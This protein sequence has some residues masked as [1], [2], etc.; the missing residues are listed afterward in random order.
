MADRTREGKQPPRIAVLLHSLEMG[1]A[2]RVLV[3]LC[4]QFAA[5]GHR[6]DMV[7]VRNQGELTANLSAQVRLVDLSAPNAYLAIPA[8]VRYLHQEEP[9]V[10]LSSF[11]LLSL[12]VLLLRRILG[13]SSQVVVRIATTLSLNRRMAYKK[14]LE[15][16]L[17]SWLYP[18]AEAIVLV[19]KSAAQ[20]LASFAGFSSER[21]HVVYNPVITD[22]FLQDM[23]ED[24]H[25]PFFEAGEPPVILGVGRLNKAKDFPSLIRAFADLRKRIPARLLILG[26]GELRVE[27]Q[28]LVN[29]LDLR[30]DVDLPGFVMNPVAYMRRSDVFVLSSRWEGLPGV[31]IQALAAG[32][33]VV[34]TDCPSGPREILADGEYGHLVPV[35]DTEALVAAIEDVLKGHGRK[36][37]PAW[38]EQFKVEP[39]VRKYMQ[40]IGIEE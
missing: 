9:Q 3:E 13:F 11:E 25:H 22:Q 36:V 35:G 10:I 32:C 8:L 20:D 12:I 19:S 31:L 27:L 7:L 40:I 24:A 37:D 33:P 2:E 28:G 17:V 15:R 29:S 18:Q 14:W 21:V 1:G 5:R 34:S 30:E 16:I 39:L 26:D 4:N 23:Q 6:I 38:L